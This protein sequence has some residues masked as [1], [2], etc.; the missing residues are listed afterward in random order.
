[1][2]EQIIQQLL[3]YCE[4]ID[5]IKDDN[6]LLQN[7]KEL[8][9]L[10][11]IRTCWAQQLCETFLNSERTEYIEIGAI[12]KCTC[13]GGIVEFTPYY[14]PYLELTSNFNVFLVRVEGISEE[15]TQIRDSDYSYIESLGLLRIDLSNYVTGDK[16][17]CKATYR[18]R[19]EYDAGYDEIPECLLQLFCDLL[20][21]IYAKNTCNCGHC[22]ACKR[23]TDEDDI[24][25]LSTGDRVTPTI[26]DYIDEV[27][28]N[29]Y[30]EQLGM[31]SLCGRE[32]TGHCNTFLG[33]VV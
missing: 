11:S 19:V 29:T 14:Y 10:I 28:V 9:H 18:I 6:Q 1:M 21:Q 8:I 17:G 3:G 30:R 16:C 7:V 20:K 24:P 27:I 26:E 22:T 5:D 32:K 25:E 33:V 15:T 23:G 12:N 31:I 2:E 13:D 4:C